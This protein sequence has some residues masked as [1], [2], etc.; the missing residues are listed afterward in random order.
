MVSFSICKSSCK[1]CFSVTREFPCVCSSVGV[2]LLLNKFRNLI[3]IIIYQD[4]CDALRNLVPCAHFKK[5]E[6]HSWRSVTF[7][8]VA[9]FSLQPKVT[10]L[11]GCFPRFLNCTNGTKSRKAPH[12]YLCLRGAMQFGIRL[13]ILQIKILESLISNSRNLFVI[14]NPNMNIFLTP[15]CLHL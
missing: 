2:E 11:L 9:G 1:I 6:K 15:Y 5:C 3:K 8:K 14:V 7:S 12:I 10:R 13:H 4:I